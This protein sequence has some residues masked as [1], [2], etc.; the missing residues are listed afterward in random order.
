[1]I[2]EKELVFPDYKQ[3]CIEVSSEAFDIMKRLLCKSSKLRLGYEKG[4]VQILEHPFFQCI[5]VSDLMAK[6]VVS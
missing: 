4:A 6:K 3:M 1:M 5:K 2:R